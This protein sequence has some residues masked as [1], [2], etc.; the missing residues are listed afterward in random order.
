MS[1][2]W[3]IFKPNPPTTSEE[4]KSIQEGGEASDAKADADG[5]KQE[6]VHS[7]ER[8]HVQLVNEAPDGPPSQG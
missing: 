8:E 1:S 3:S 7:S 6:A 5:V 2:A 4:P